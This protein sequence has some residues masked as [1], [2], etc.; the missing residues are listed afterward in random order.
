MW[1]LVIFLVFANGDQQR[2]G[3]VAYFSDF[4]SCE[5][6]FPLIGA[7]E[8]GHIPMNR[9]RRYELRCEEDRQ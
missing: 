7:D 2:L 4:L 1:L 8:R 5:S 6:H 3:V 9:G